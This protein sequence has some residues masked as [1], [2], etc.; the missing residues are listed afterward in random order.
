MKITYIK[1]MILSLVLLFSLSVTT[2]YA[3]V[4]QEQIDQA[5]QQVNQLQ[6]QVQDAEN[7][8]GLTSCQVCG[9]SFRRGV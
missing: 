5:Q 7:Q 6:Q 9:T 8:V 1:R 4:T 3:T 2:V